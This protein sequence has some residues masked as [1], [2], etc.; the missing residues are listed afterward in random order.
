M[1]LKMLLYAQLGEAINLADNPAYEY[2]R[3]SII[4]FD[5]I[6]ENLLKK[7]ILEIIFEKKRNKEIVIF[8]FEKI[9]NSINS[10]YDFEKDILK[11]AAKF[12][13]IKKEEQDILSFCHKTRNNVYHNLLDD[14]MTIDLCISLYFEF[15]IANFTKLILSWISSCDSRQNSYKIILERNK[16]SSYNEIINK[17]QC[18]YEKNKS[19]KFIMKEILNEKF[20]MV[21]SFWI[22]FSDQNW[23][24]FNELLL[25]DY[26]YHKIKME[27]KIDLQT[28][29]FNEIE[30]KIKEFS[31]RNSIGNF[32]QKKMNKLE[33]L[34]NTI[35]NLDNFK[36][37]E[38]F[39]SKNN[40]INPFIRAISDFNSKLENDYYNSK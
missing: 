19:S 7:K 3:I 16:V 20:E 28:L 4:L 30:E 37:F 15:F 10:K 17:L 35:I 18:I 27:G 5:N 23:E 36:A 40:E 2:K 8:D 38:D 13:L 33:W 6:I 34:I 26:Y 11:N 12:Y 21:Y 29:N 31:K 24:K 9:N 32:T 39:K 14:F 1:P 25:P 22:N